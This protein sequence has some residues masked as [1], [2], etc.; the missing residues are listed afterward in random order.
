MNEVFVVF[1]SL[2]ILICWGRVKVKGKVK[3]SVW[4][5]KHCAMGDGSIVPNI[6]DLGT[7]RR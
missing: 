4:L 5:T 7:G 1:H 3:L 2:S 6:L